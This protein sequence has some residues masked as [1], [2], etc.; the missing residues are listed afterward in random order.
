M[1]PLESIR[2]ALMCIS[3]SFN[4]FFWG[5]LGTGQLQLSLKMKW[6]AIWL[7]S[8]SLIRQIL[9]IV[10]LNLSND[11]KT[12]LILSLFQEIVQ[13]MT[14]VSHVLF[15]IEILK[16]FCVLTSWLSERL[17]KWTQVLAVV[18]FFPCLV[19]LVLVYQ[20]WDPASPIPFEIVLVSLLM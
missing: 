16:V 19:A 20:P 2:I 18:A 8:I 17:L 7:F 3:T 6:Y 1:L 10:S 4:L 15:Q 11:P 9:R 13:E 12:L 14:L 5:L